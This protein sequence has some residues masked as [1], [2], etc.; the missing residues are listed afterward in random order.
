MGVLETEETRSEPAHLEYVPKSH[1]S[2]TVW[3]R[4]ERSSVYKYISAAVS[5]RCGEEVLIL[6]LPCAQVMM[7][8]AGQTFDW[9]SFERDKKVRRF[10]TGFFTT[11]G[12]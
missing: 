8:Y 10:C 5:L 6:L 12:L 11:G 7:K 4:E 1:W 3:P 2:A 9:K